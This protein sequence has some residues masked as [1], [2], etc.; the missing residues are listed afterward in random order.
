MRRNLIRIIL[1]IFLTAVIAGCHS[2]FSGQVFDAE[3]GRPIE[4]AF[5]FGQWTV[6]KGLPGLTYHEISAVTETLT[7]HNGKFSLSGSMNPFAN[8]P[9]VVVYKEGYAAWRNDYIFPSWE[10]RKSRGGGKIMLERFKDDYSYF[11]YSS[12]LNLAIMKESLNLSEIIHKVRIEAERRANIQIPLDFS[13]KVV[14]AETGMPIEGALLMAIGRGWGYTHKVNTV[15]EG[16]SDKEGNV[17]ITGKFPMLENPPCVLVYKK[18][19]LVRSSWRSMADIYEQLT[20]FKWQNGFV[21]KLNKWGDNWK[22]IEDHFG[23][24]YNIAAHYAE[25]EGKP[26]LL[27]SILWEKKR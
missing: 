25:Q 8:Y 7:D 3:T 15:V 14:D 13:G 21:F 16:I 18:G 26:L 23:F 27:D 19:Y 6:T 10:K 2:R 11:K 1:L 17:R 22:P 9:E 4:R 24:I 12:F 5:V 20:D